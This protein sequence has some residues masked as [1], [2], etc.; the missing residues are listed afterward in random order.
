MLTPPPDY[1]HAEVIPGLYVGAFPPASR[2]IGARMSWCPWRP[3]MP[4]SRY[5]ETSC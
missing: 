3:P 1:D 4:V 2:S 5:P